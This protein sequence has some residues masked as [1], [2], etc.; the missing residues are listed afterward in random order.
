MIKKIN[1]LFFKYNKLFAISISTFLA[2]LLTIS[3]RYYFFFILHIDLL[4]ISDYPH[5]CIIVLFNIN[6]IRF[7]V[8][9]I[10]QSVFNN[11][12]NKLSSNG[13]NNFFTDNNKLN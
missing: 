4:K 5:I 3:V 10:L 6:L 8:K 11:K 9:F 7:Y 12:L 1:I 13:F 2:I